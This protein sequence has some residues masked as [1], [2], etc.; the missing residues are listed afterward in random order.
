M[1]HNFKKLIADSPDY[2][3]KV[4]DRQSEN[5]WKPL[6]SNPTIEEVHQEIFNHYPQ[7]VLEV[8]CGWGRLTK[9]LNDMMNIPVDGCDYLPEMI[10]KCDDSFNSFQWDCLTNSPK[11]NK[12]WDVLFTRGVMCYFVEDDLMK[13]ALENILKITNKCVIFWEW[14]DTIDVM[15]SITNDPKVIYKVQ[16]RKS[17]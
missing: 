11:L 6:T 16:E 1:S 9:P 8:G 3:L 12:T 17:E 14:Q 13:P 10:T 2:M 15:K 7:S 4:F 5:G